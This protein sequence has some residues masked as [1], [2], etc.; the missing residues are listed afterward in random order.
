VI[1]KMSK[2][3]IVLNGQAYEMEIE[4]IDGT[5]STVEAKAQTSAQS[6]ANN[7]AVADASSASTVNNN[8]VASNGIVISPMPGTV[9]KV[10]A[11]QGD[12]VEAG[13]PVLVLEAM[14]MENEITAP[15]S[16]VISAMYVGEGK[17]VAGGEALFEIGE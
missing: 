1:I 8:D 9:V 2:Y 7:N 11:A 6:A 4:A 15:K 17:T 12:K 16:G 3:K 10:T 5:V 14:K 13:Q